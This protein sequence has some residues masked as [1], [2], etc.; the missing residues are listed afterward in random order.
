VSSTYQKVILIGNVGQDPN[1][2]EDGSSVPRLFFSLATEEE[3]KKDGK[4]QKK[5]Q[6]HD[7]VV[8]DKYALSAVNIIKKGCKVAV[9]GRIDYYK[10][11]GSK[12]NKAT[13]VVSWYRIINSPQEDD[14]TYVGGHSLFD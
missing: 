9:E 1:F 11:E 7:C 8:Y 5:V 12:Y 6:W 14:T 3:W 10:P 2:K 13:I 4:Q